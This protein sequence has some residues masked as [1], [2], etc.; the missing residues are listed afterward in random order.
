[1]LFQ[2]KSLK[3]LYIV[4]LLYNFLVMEYIDKLEFYFML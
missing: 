3:Y 1:M 4:N 2:D